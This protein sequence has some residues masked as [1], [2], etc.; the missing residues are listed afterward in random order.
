MNKEKMTEQE[1]IQAWKSNEYMGFGGMPPECQEW[2]R[3]HSGLDDHYWLV[4]SGTD[5]HDEIACASHTVYRLHPD[6]QPP[7]P[8]PSDSDWVEL[9]IE[10]EHF[11]MP[12]DFADK[13][14]NWQDYR[15]PAF[16]GTLTL[17][18][19][20]VLTK[21]GGW[22]WPDWNCWAE[23]IQPGTSKVPKKIRF[24]AERIPE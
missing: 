12:L 19:G 21:F 24:W 1:I 23:T 5:L 13:W 16:R 17:P 18:D 9:E 7:A 22:Y 4:G 10:E 2:A 3:E 11:R 8:K 20:R 14:R 6:Y 15:L